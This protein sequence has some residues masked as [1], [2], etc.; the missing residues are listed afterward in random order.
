GDPLLGGVALDRGAALPDGAVVAQ[1]VQEV[2]HGHP[3]LGPV[4]P[5]RSVGPCHTDPGGG[6]GISTTIEVPM[7][8]D[9][10]KKSVRMRIMSLLIELADPCGARG[11]AGR[12]RWCPSATAAGCGQRPTPASHPARPAAPTISASGT[13]VG[14]RM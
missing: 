7:P 6:L 13:H 8:R 1:A 4:G 5:G 2:E 10:A 12:A 3:V 11:G 9:S 14:P